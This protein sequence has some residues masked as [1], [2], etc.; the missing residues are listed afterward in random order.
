MVR[1]LQDGDRI[2]QVSINGSRDKSVTGA[3]GEEP[4]LLRWVAGQFRPYRGKVGLVGVLILVTAGL[5]TA[6]PLLVKVVF[7]QALFV[8]GGPNVGLLGLL[9]G[10]MIAIT[11]VAGGLSVWRAYLTNTV[12]QQVMSDLR[13][14]LYTQLQALSLRFFTATRTGEIQSRL[15]NDVGGLQTA[16]TDT[17]STILSSTVILISTIAAMAMLSWQMTLLSLAILPLFGWQALV[18]GRARRRVSAKTQ[19]ALADMSAIVEETLSVSG[20]LLT[21]IFGRQAAETDRYAAQNE[22]LTALQVRQQM[23]KQGFSIGVV[24]FFSLTP[25]LIYLVV[26]R[27]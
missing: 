4:R 20:I 12:G 22:R 7:D 3:K 24:T 23:I 14:R 6:N 26:S 9:V 1:G 5:G 11:I 17:A 27:R 13:S 18:A 15:A 2:V 8:P 19:V 16:I 10:L 25:A 21:K